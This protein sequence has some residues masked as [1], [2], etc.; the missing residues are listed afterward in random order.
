MSDI[1]PDNIR[2]LMDYVE[3]E[4]A[5]STDFIAK[6]AENSLF[7]ISQSHHWHLQSTKY[8]DHMFFEELY[9][10]LPEYV[11]K[12][13]ECMVQA[14]GLLYP[15]GYEF[16]FSSI[17]TAVHD[18]ESYKKQCEYL[19][20]IIDIVSISTAI[21]STVEFIDGILYKLKMLS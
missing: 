6:F 14:W 13:L 10:D 21:E 15:T 3:T 2:E 11:D 18:L 9:K 12:V 20:E 19:L 16:T 17:D 5:D 7:L 8:S 4:S 1:T